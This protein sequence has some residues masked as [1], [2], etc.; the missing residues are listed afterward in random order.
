MLKA[1]LLRSKLDKKNKELKTLLAQGEDLQKREAEL[2]Q[3]IAESA[4]ATEEEQKV[5][6]E[7]VDKFNGEKDA[8]DAAK[9]KLEDEIAG[10]ENDLKETEAEQEAEPE[11]PEKPAEEAPKQERKVEHTMNKR[12]FNMSNQERDAF[13][14]REDVKEFLSQVRTGI[15][16]KRALSNVG[17]L[18]PEVFLG[19]LREN[20]AEYSKLYKHV[21]VRPVAGESRQVVMGNV[22]EAVW[23]DCCANLN[24]LNLTFNDVELNCWKVGGYFAVC[25]ANVEDSDIDLMA[26]LLVALG[27]A[28]GLALDKAILYGTGTRMPLGVVTRLAQTEAPA[29]YPATARPWVDLHTTNILSIAATVK[30]KDLISTIVKDFGAAKGKYSRGEKVWIMNEATYTTLMANTVAVTATGQLVAGVAD[31]MPVVGGIIEVL[32]F[33]P[34]N[35]IIAGYFDLYTLAERAGTKFATSE[36]VR[37]L[38]DQTVMK[39]TARYDGKPVIAEGFV[40]I[41]LN[42]V[43]PN[44]TMTFAADTAN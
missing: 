39:G 28:I 27:Q 38:Q 13:F 24:E 26:E 22:P 9:K 33:I 23:T 29:D 3:A 40:A 42:G 10:L 8:Y 11:E 2:E 6:E 15:R 20:V 31:R 5:V 7:E 25:N 1:L 41:G 35:V 44:A 14:A 21:F 32:N 19:I 17:L 34:D 30:D 37:F 36:H 12:F 18:I 43:T 4:E 16:E